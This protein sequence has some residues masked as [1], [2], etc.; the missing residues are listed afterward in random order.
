[1]ESV[2]E[3]SE[4]KSLCDKARAFLELVTETMAD[5]VLQ[6][7]RNEPR[8]V[9]SNLVYLPTCETSES[10]RSSR[11]VVQERRF[12]DLLRTGFKG[13]IFSR[14]NEVSISE[15]EDGELSLE[16][17]FTRYGYLGANRYTCTLEDFRDQSF[18]CEHVE[19]ILDLEA[20]MVKRLHGQSKLRRTI[21]LWAD[22]F[23]DAVAHCREP[24][25][26]L[27]EM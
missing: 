10:G 18:V 8:R 25:C 23:R 3:S 7:E 26:S 20:R 11:F 24:R 2:K 6:E 15:T 9:G 19:R 12:A 16:V 27:D 21:G 5:G 13:P 4:F 14:I 17:T 1:M 22:Y